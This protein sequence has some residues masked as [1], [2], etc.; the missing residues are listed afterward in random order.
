MK[1]VRAADLELVS[2]LYQ[3]CEPQLSEREL[4][5]IQPYPDSLIDSSSSPKSSSWFEKGLS[6]ISLGKVCVVLLSGGQGTRLGSSL[7]KGMLD[8]GL[9]SHKSIFQRFAEYILKLELLAADRCGHTGSI[10]L[11]ILTS[12][13][14]TQEVNK[15]FK[16]NNN[17]GLLSNNV[18]IIEQPSLPCVS[19]DTGEVLMVS[20]KDA[21][22]SP[23]GNGGLIDAL[24]ENNT[25]SNMDERG[26][27]YIHVVGVDNVL[28]RVAD[29]SF[30]GY[31]ISMNAPCG[32]ESIGLTR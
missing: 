7:P 19:L 15:F 14:T 16:D 3:S 27:R 24:R 11:Y 1:N 5:S 9:P 32:S 20:A 10:P 8:I 31:V 23:N 25:L 21:A 17:F 26:I 18:I 28:T 4:K 22:T 12:I 29:P 6:A 2:K 30:I 13:S